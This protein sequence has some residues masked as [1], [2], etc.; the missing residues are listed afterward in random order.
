MYV[1]NFIIPIIL[2]YSKNCNYFGKP[3][4]LL[5]WSIRYSEAYFMNVSQ[6]GLSFVHNALVDI[7]PHKWKVA[8]LLQTPFLF[9]KDNS[10]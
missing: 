9:D 7:E 3:V 1:Y 5:S 8:L 2:S 10:C 4:T 6:L